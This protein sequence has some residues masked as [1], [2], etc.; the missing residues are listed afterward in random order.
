MKNDLSAHYK[1]HR[2]PKDASPLVGCRGKAPLLLGELSQ[3][4]RQ[5]AAILIILRFCR[6]IDAA[7]E[8]NFLCV[9]LI[10]DDERNFLAGKNFLRNIERKSFISCNAERLPALVFRKTERENS[11]ADEIASVDPFETL[12]NNCAHAEKGS[13][14]CGPIARAAH[15][16]VFAGKEDE[17]DVSFG[18]L[19]SGI[20]DRHESIVGHEFCKTSLFSICE[21]VRNS[22]VGKRASHHDLMIASPAAVAVEFF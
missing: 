11:H 18:V 8:G 6:G 17:R 2:I 22:N 4:V 7:D 5:D 13:S 15:A 9:I 19:L 16:I 21:V 3:D 10:F 1:N 12:R 20:E 14:L